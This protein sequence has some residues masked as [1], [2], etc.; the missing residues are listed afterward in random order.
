MMILISSFVIWLMRLIVRCSPHSV[1][2]GFFGRAMNAEVHRSLGRCPV[3]QTLF[4]TF[5]RCSTP[6]S[7]MLLSTLCT[8]HQVWLPSCFHFLHSISHFF[9]HYVR[10]FFKA[11]HFKIIVSVTVVQI[12]YVLCLS[13]PDLILFHNND[14]DNDNVTSIAPV[15]S[16][17]P[18]SRALTIPFNMI[19][20]GKSPV[21]I[22]VERK[23]CSRV[24]KNLWRIGKTK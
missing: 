9:L 15:S 22:P 19:H 16:K 21:T 6:T 3:L 7:S 23:K 24:T 11:F 2:P 12:L 20:K 1:A 18:S 5:V 4:K 8:I 10:S 14:N 13:F 17:Q